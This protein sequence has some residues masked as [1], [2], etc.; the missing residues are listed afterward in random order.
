MLMAVAWANR[1]KIEWKRRKA[2]DF[3]RAMNAN[4][5]MRYDYKEMA[6]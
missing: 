5:V 4:R 3:E 2:G 6:M 1:P